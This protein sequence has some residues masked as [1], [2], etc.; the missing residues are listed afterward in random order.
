MGKGRKLLKANC[1][2]GII[3]KKRINDRYAIEIKAFHLPECLYA[4][5]KIRFMIIK[6][7][8]VLAL[9]ELTEGLEELTIVFKSYASD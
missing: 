2:R 8:Y 9:D 1:T 5:V 3:D 7:D 6:M 4:L